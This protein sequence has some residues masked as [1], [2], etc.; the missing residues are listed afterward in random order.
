MTTGCHENWLGVFQECR[1]IVLRSGY[2]D[3][4]E[5]ALRCVD[6]CQLPHIHK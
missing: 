1:E 3:V 4:S 6:A 5:G 2:F